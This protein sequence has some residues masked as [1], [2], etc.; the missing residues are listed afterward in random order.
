MTFS[1]FFVRLTG[2]LKNTKAKTEKVAVNEVAEEE[3]TGAAI[4]QIKKKYGY[5]SS[6]SSKLSITQISS[7]MQGRRGLFLMGF[8]NVNAGTGGCKRSEDEAE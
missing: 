1:T 7:A 4:D 3:K 6:V 5:A 8:R 2:K